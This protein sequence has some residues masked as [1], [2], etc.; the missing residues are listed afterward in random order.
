MDLSRSLGLAWGRADGPMSRRRR[1][2]DEFC[3]LGADGHSVSIIGVRTL[4]DSVHASP[5]RR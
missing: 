2:E 1:D 4:W 3:E 5:G